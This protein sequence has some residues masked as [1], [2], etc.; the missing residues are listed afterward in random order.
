MTIP[1]YDALGADY[2]RFCDWSERLAF[3]LP[4]LRRQLEAAGARQVLDLA[5]GTG[6][7]AIALSR[8]GFEVVG[9]D[10]SE[11]LLRL[12]EENA[13]TAGAEVRFHALGFGQISARMP[14]QFQAITCLGN[15]LPHALGQVQLRAA[16]A[17]MATALKPGG[18]LVL[19]LRNFLPVLLNKRRFMHPEAH[20]RGDE[21]WLFYRFYD[22]DEAPERL[23]F[24]MLRLYKRGDAPWTSQIDSIMLS[25]WGEDNLTETLAAQGFS[26]KHTMAAWL[27]SR[28]TAARAGIWSSWP[29]RPIDHCFLQRTGLA[30]GVRPVVYSRARE[31]T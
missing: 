20:K 13:A 18:R 19:Q 7:H 16:L 30:L 23:R 1:F 10:P 28:S 22:L 31:V 24:N 25:P 27:A 14:Q 5:C 15:S 6:Q 26:S 12:A 2:D 3:E 21:E 11:G 29:T 4:F 17:D 8:A 9:A